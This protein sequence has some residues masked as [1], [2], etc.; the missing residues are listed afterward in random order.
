MQQLKKTGSSPFDLVFNAVGETDVAVA[1]SDRLARFMRQG[2][3][4]VLNRLSAI[5]ST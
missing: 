1:L 2:D 5:A 3:R 4:P